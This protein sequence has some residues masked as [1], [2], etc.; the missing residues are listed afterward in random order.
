MKDSYMLYTDKLHGEYRV[1]FDQI[2][3][4]VGTLFID[5]YTREEHMNEL[6]DMF[7]SAQESGKPVKKIVGSNV[8]KFCKI[9][10]SDFGA[11]NLLKSIFES[12]KSIAIFMLIVSLADVLCILIDYSQ[13]Q[14]TDFWNALTTGT[15]H[16]FLALLIGLV[17]GFTVDI[18]LR[19]IMF[20]IKKVS[21]NALKTITFS[22]IIVVCIST[23]VFIKPIDCPVWIT[24][25]SS[26]AYLIIYYA[27]NF[28]KIRENNKHKVHFRNMLN[29]EINADFPRTMQK[30]YEKKNAR[31]I[32]RG[33]GTL[34]IEDFIKQ[35]EKS[36]D[37]NDKIR[38]LYFV[39]PLVLTTII[40]L[41][42]YFT[43]GFDNTLDIIL[44][45]AI[46][47]LIEYPIMI[48]FRRF[49]KNNTNLTRKWIQAKKKELT[50]D[51]EI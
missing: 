14:V 8:E 25:L 10:C 38:W 9:F 43:G 22:A 37:F 45:A 11:K 44:F 51:S 35:Q 3:T 17:F 32:K 6:L 46:M 33:K 16:H 5:E 21:V 20:R 13:G 30:I 34:S 19:K 15:S 49:D 50:E 28:K 36:C 4:Y 26:S 39:F 27:F 29:E 24:L 23:C 2:D 1:V 47:L 40:L 41:L 18:I 7:L 31:H 12:L 42:T 48:F